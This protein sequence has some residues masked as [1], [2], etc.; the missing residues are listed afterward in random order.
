MPNGP[1]VTKLA[2][3]QPD[4]ANDGSSSVYSHTAKPA[5]RPANAPALVAPFQYRP[6]ITAGANCATAANEMSPIATS[7]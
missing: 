5:A 2:G 4:F 1:S 7:A 6:P 3:S